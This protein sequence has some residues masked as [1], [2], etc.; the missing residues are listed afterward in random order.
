M[1]KDFSTAEIKEIIDFYL[2]TDKDPSLYRLVYEYDEVVEA[3]EKEAAD[4]EARK[5]LLA[6]TQ[7]RVQE[8]RERYG[9]AGK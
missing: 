4:L 6:E 9:N 8:F 3:M 7:K 5:A 2:K 1:L